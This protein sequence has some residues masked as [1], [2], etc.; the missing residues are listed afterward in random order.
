ME[1]SKETDA[2]ESTLST[3][4]NNDEED[5]VDGTFLDNIL[6]LLCKFKFI[7]LP[8]GYIIWCHNFS[9]QI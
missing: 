6:S 7:M 8:I 9:V 4:S 1:P 5:C 2:E 3:T